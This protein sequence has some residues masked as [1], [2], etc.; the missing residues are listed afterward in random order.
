MWAIELASDQVTEQLKGKN[1]TPPLQ[2]PL[3][4]ILSSGMAIF[5]PHHRPLNTYICSCNSLQGVTKKPV[6]IDS[7]WEIPPFLLIVHNSRKRS[8]PH[9]YPQAWVQWCYYMG[10]RQRCSSTNCSN[11]VDFTQKPS[12]YGSNFIFFG[13]VNGQYIKTNSRSSTRTSQ[14][15]VIQCYSPARVIL[16]HI[17]RCPRGSYHPLWSNLIC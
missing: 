16:A 2:T 5:P 1:R 8:R 3:G 7:W 13:G 12:H 4:T 15:Q 6:P 10:L 14:V 11:C 17:T 9:V